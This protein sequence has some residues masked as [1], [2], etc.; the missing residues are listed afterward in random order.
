MLTSCTNFKNIGRQIFLITF[1]KSPTINF[2]LSFQNPTLNT[3]SFLLLHSTEYSIFVTGPKIWN[4]LY[5]K[6]KEEK[7]I[8]S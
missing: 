1:L 4:K 7:E 6:K 5:T 2:L 3:K 8:H